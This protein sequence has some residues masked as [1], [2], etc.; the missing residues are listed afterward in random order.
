MPDSFRS[1]AQVGDLSSAGSRRTLFEMTFP[2]GTKLRV[3]KTPLLVLKTGY[4]MELD[5]CLCRVF[6]SL[7]P[8]VRGRR[9][10]DHPGRVKVDHERKSELFSPCASHRI[11]AVKHGLSVIR[12]RHK[13]QQMRRAMEENRRRTHNRVKDFA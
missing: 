2:I 9:I 7:T 12:G 6:L 4:F 3:Q 11:H 13:I 10:E 8:V 1:A 5:E